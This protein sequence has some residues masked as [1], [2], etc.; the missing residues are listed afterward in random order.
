MSVLQEAKRTVQSY[1]K[2]LESI[3]FLEGVEALHNFHTGGLRWMGVY[4]FGETE[5]PQ[6]VVD[7]F[8]KP[9]K[10]ALTCLQQREEIFFAG[11]NEIDD[12]QTVW[13]ASMG[14]FTGL[15]DEPWLDIPPTGKLAAL[16]YCT[17]HRVHGEK[18]L[19][20]VMHVD[21]PLFMAQAGRNPFPAQTGSTVRH[22]GPRTGD[23]LL[24]D[25]QTDS[26]AGK[27]LAAI[28]GMINNLGTWNSGLPLEEELAL[29]WHED[30]TWWGP[31]GIGSA[32]TIERYARQHARPFR[33][34]FS[35]RSA[36]NHIARLAE[37]SYGGFF[38]WPNFTAKSSGG[39]M[40][41]PATEQNLEF[42]VIDIYRRDHD[43]LA[44]N[45]V[46]IDLLYVWKQ[47]GVDL[48]AINR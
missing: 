30:M 18:I 33:Q 7:T 35:D 23:G 48:L 14:H 27:T 45:W 28:N 44:E 42:R 38:G 5:S 11:Y 4:P 25:P 22:C 37:G 9:L 32:H 43:K 34:G 13:V 10:Y 6:A 26:E 16:R 8:W 12:Q 40:G 47:M 29:N 24:L 2:L 41:M 39:F 21:I 31:H 1:H 20:T 46:F 17:I 36:T 19:E 15:F 3:D